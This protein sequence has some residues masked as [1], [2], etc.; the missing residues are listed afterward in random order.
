MVLVL[1]PST[2]ARGGVPF[3]G[4]LTR[5]RLLERKFPGMFTPILDDGLAVCLSSSPTIPFMTVYPN[6]ASYC[7]LA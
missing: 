5:Y 4:E 2:F 6:L 7:V 3:E 1:A